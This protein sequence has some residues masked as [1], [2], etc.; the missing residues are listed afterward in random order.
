MA[1]PATLPKQV[2]HSTVGCAFLVWALGWSQRVRW[3]W[4]V[5]RVSG[6]SPGASFPDSAGCVVAHLLVTL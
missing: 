1:Y 5:F 6:S 4:Y 2:D 3:G